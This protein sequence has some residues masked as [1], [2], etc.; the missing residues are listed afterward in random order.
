M[1][2]HVAGME[3]HIEVQGH[4]R[5][6]VLVHG[7][8]SRASCWEEVVPGL[9]D[10]YQVFTFDMR[11]FG[12]TVRPASPQMSFEVWI[13]DLRQLLDEMELTSVGLVGWSLGGLIAMN[14]VLQY[15]ALVSDLIL[16]GVASPK[17][18]PTDRSGFDTRLRLAQ[19][20]ATADEIVRQ[21][22][23]FTRRAFS[24]YTEANNPTAIDKVR[25]EHLSND[26][27]SYAEMVLANRQR[28]KIGERLEEIRCP[29][30]VMV[31]DADT[32]TPMDDA[33]ELNIEIPQSYLKILKNCG[34][35]STYEQPAAVAR[36]ISSFLGTDG[37][38]DTPRVGTVA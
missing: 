18:V 12:E 6:I 11:G 5:P 13:D 30:L 23:D 31:G 33:I 4:G 8:G 22:F 28:P 1:L 35:F 20:G 37:V 24:P 9:V 32:R 16:I 10:R 2:R 36:M 19:E 7:G 3:M 26:P 38:D 25:A 34:H 27:K 21:T 17:R 14:F 15:P 29:T